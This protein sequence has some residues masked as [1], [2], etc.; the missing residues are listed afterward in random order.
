MHHRICSLTYAHPWISDEPEAVS[1]NIELIYT[2]VSQLGFELER[3]FAQYMQYT[4]VRNA[5]WS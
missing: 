4:D 3:D 2:H 1:L 5:D